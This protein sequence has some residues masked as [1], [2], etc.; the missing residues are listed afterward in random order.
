MRIPTETKLSASCSHPFQCLNMSVK[1]VASIFGRV[2]TCVRPIRLLLLLGYWRRDRDL[3]FRTLASGERKSI[4]ANFPFHCRASER[5][6]YSLVS[7]TA[8]SLS[9][10]GR[11]S[12]CVRPHRSLPPLSPLLARSAAQ[13]SFVRETG[14]P[15]RWHNFCDDRPSGRS[16][17][18]DWTLVVWT[19]EDWRC[20]L[21]ISSVQ[22]VTKDL[23]K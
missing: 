14:N 10:G 23:H 13:G 21:V 1:K 5:R 11:R 12:P 20:P 6:P 4:K 7:T 16:T 18:L 9:D 19:L 3:L 8:P 17:W 15:P 22:W 2:F